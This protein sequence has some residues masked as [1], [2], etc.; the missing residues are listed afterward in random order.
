VTERRIKLR[1]KLGSPAVV[2]NVQQPSSIS[3]HVDEFGT[4]MVT[5]Q[6]ADIDTVP[7]LGKDM[8]TRSHNASAAND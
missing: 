6:A 5:M 7:P 2:L 1:R 4:V 8:S 3:V